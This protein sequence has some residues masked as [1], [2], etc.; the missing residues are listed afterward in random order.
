[1]RPAQIAQPVATL[2]DAAALARAID[3][4]G[5]TPA[6]SAP[7]TAS[8]LDPTEA[9][10]RL[11]RMGPN[12]VPPPAPDRWPVRV[13]RQLKDPMAR[14]ARHVARWRRGRRRTGEAN[15]V[16]LVRGRLGASPSPGSDGSQETA[17]GPRRGSRH[18]SAPD[19]R[20]AA[21][22]P[23]PR[24]R[25]LS[26]PG[27]PSRRLPACRAP[28][29]C[30]GRVGRRDPEQPQPRTDRGRCS[31]PCGPCTPARHRWSWSLAGRPASILAACTTAWW[32]SSPPVRT[33]SSSS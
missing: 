33:T 8:G 29:V 5:P 27:A 13:A 31:P 12:E 20:G 17:T 6:P 23:R 28:G 16:K 30:P 1:M 10:A 3:R 14:T 24:R 15:R 19:D 26:G 7:V 32:S 2:L 22:D 18:R 25:V 4:P 21:A 9:A 11:A